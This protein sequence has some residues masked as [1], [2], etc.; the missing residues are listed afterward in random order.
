MS[1]SDGTSSFEL[2][3]N[4]GNVLLGDG[5]GGVL[6]CSGVCG[7]VSDRQPRGEGSATWAQAQRPYRCP[8]CEGKGI[9]SHGFYEIGSVSTNSPTTDRCRS[10]AGSGVVW[11]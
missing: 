9:V 6:V 4:W 11:G 3:E 5:C 1:R 8:I 2:K 7:S 10:C